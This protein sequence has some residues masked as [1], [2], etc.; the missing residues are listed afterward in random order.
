MLGLLNNLF[1]LF[2]VAFLRGKYSTFV[3]FVPEVL[4]LLIFAIFNSPIQ[5]IIEFKYGFMLQSSE[6]DIEKIGRAHV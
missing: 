6:T 1:S 3:L 5:T 2:V 4:L